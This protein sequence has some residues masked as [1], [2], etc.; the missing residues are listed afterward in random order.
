MPGIRRP[1][2]SDIQA[3][4]SM[5]SAF[6]RPAPHRGVSSLHRDVASA[7][8]AEVRRIASVGGERGGQHP[9]TTK[10]ST[11]VPGRGTSCTSCMAMSGAG[12]Q[13]PPVAASAAAPE[14][15]V[16]C[17]TLVALGLLARSNGRTGEPIN[18]E[19]SL[20]SSEDETPATSHYCI[21]PRGAGRRRA[22]FRCARTRRKEVGGGYMTCTPGA[23][24][25]TTPRHVKAPRPRH[26]QG[27]G[28]SKSRREGTVCTGTGLEAHTGTAAS[29]TL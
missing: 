28:G 22:A 3:R 23:T 16:G 2:R 29:V 24:S 11:P 5:R 1:S 27:H 6:F 26:G 15:W 17:C 9:S 4:K 25:D 20:Q 10:S 21:S 8:R 13:L 7:L 12:S 14:P 19:R 18:W